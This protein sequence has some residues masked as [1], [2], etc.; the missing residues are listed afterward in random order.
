MKGSSTNFSVKDNLCFC[1][2]IDNLFQ[3]MGICHKPNEWRLFI[4]SSSH[5]NKCVLLHNG[6]QYPS[7]PSSDYENVKIYSGNY[8]LQ[9][10]QMAGLW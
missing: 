3:E 2:D 4:D 10:I 8:R 1:N 5:S 7:I 9:Q 6:T